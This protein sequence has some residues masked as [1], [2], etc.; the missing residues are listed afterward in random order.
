[1]TNFTELNSSDNES[2]SEDIEERV[3]NKENVYKKSKELVNEMGKNEH[4]ANFND[5]IDE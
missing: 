5:Y 3:S 1:N 2:K 4:V